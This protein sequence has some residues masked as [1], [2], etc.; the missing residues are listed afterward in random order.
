MAPVPVDRGQ[1][2]VALNHGPH[3]VL[4]LVLPMRVGVLVVVSQQ[5]GA[6]PAAQVATVR[7]PVEILP[8]VAVLLQVAAQRQAEVHRQ[9]AVLPLAGAVAAAGLDLLPVV[10]LVAATA[11]GLAILPLVVAEVVVPKGAALAKA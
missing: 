1:A 5:A 8:L 6:T 2:R 9:V 7:V 11:K 4:R 3:C 10:V